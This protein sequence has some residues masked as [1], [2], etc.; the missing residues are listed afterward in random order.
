M[1]LSILIQWAIGIVLG[2]GAVSHIDE[3]HQELIRAQAKLIYESRTSTWGSPKFFQDS[4][5]R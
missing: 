4:T 5:S 2:L 3:I 1:N